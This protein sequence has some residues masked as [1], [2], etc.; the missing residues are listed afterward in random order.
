MARTI[1]E[2]ENTSVKIPTGESVYR[3]TPKDSNDDL[4]TLRKYVTVD[5]IDRA[6]YLQFFANHDKIETEYRIKTDLV[7]P[8]AKKRVNYAND[9]MQTDKK[10]SKIISEMQI[11]ELVYDNIQSGELNWIDDEKPEPRVKNIKAFK[12][13]YNGLYNDVLYQ[14]MDDGMALGHGYQSLGREIYNSGILKYALN[15]GNDYLKIRISKM[16]TE[17]KNM[18]KAEIMQKIFIAWDKV[19]P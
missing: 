12:H 16:Q 15:E 13:T 8:S 3:I 10:F 5:D 17:W 6:H 9:L 1:K 2:T 11:G 19:H 18:S 4:S 7:I 14:M